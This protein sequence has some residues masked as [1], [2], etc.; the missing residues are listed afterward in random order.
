M[1]IKHSNNQSLNLNHSAMYM[2]KSKCL[3]FRSLAGTVLFLFLFLFSSCTDENEQMRSSDRIRFTTRVQNA[4]VDLGGDRQKAATRSSV[5]ALQSEGTN[6]LFLHTLYIDSIASPFADDTAPATRAIPRNRDNMYDTF[7]ISA[8]SYTGAWDGTQLPDFMYDVSVAKRGSSW[9]PDSNPYWPGSAYKMKFFAYAPKGSDAYR[10]SDRGSAGAP[11]ITCAIPAD[12]AEQHD[13]LVAASTEVSG[14]TNTSVDLLFRHAL[15]AVKFVCG[16][17][18]KA[19]TV[20]SVTLKGVNSTGVYRF[21]THAWSGI[22]MVKD[23]SQTLDKASSGTAGEAI[24]ADAQTFMMIPQT[25]SENAKIEIVFDDGTGQRT[26]TGNIAGSEWPMGKTVT[27][28]ISTTSLN[29]EYVLTVNPPAEF[30]YTGGT[31]NYSVTSY[32]EDSKGEK[33]PVKWKAQFSTDGGTTW[34]DTKPDWLTAF[35]TSGE[36][37]MTAASFNATVNAQTGTDNNAHTTALQNATPK[38]SSTSAYNLSNQTNGGSTIQNTANCYVVSAPGYYSFPLVYGNAIK[39]GATNSSAYHTDVT[40]TT[41][42]R[43]KILTDFINHLGNAITDPHIA[44]NTGC[45]PANAELV[46]QDAPSLVS[47][48][49]YNAGSSG[50]NISFKVDKNTIR[51]GNAVIAIKDA[52][53]TTLWSWHIWVTD[54]NLNNTIEVTNYQKMKYKLMPVN[55]GWCEGETVTYAARDCKVRFTAGE[56]TTDITVSQLKAEIT[57]SNN[58]TFYQ[59]GRKDP[60][61][62]SNGVSGNQILYDANNAASAA[63]VKVESFPNGSETIKNYILKPDVMQK[64]IGGDNTYY[65][66]WSADNN[67]YSTNDNPVVKTIYDPCPV[68]F[69]LPAPNAFTGF[70]TTGNHVASPSQVN[71]SWD[72]TRKG[73]NFYTQANRSGQQIFFPASGWR[74]FSDGSLFSVGSYGYCWSAGPSSL[75]YGWGLK[76]L[77]SEVYPFGSLYRSD[78]LSLRPVQEPVGLQ[79][80]GIQDWADGGTI[81]IDL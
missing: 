43:D 17:D 4:W 65:N 27:Y 25:L 74:Y 5:A 41:N 69:N 9:I 39:G 63:N 33:V 30:S 53:N 6:P 44:Y 8:Y 62:P 18:M 52:S 42:G 16:S 72:S 78:G 38:G 2:Y 11:T 32:K 73:W 13:L 20:K 45:T 28:K 51:Q 81:E 59:W 34:S 50:G 70:T 40:L 29:W 60:L 36:G 3:L 55:L 67:T 79:P 22:G 76:F 37:G 66:L 12:V 48:I 75:G 57:T 14:N 23:F 21:E 54:E 80:S 24:T 61:R 71:G 26:L 68:G 10:L 47:E 1:I 7:G 15:T 31:N 49:K 64:S 19:G 46:W 56:R 35:T 77:L 58:N